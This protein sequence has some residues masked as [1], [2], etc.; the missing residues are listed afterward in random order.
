VLLNRFV[1]L[2]YSWTDLKDHLPKVV[3]IYG[4]HDHGP[5]WVTCFGVPQIVHIKDLFCRFLN[6]HIVDATKD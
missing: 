5:K 1:R 6:M 4:K 3:I 2:M